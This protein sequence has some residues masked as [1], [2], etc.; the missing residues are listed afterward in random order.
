[1]TRYAADTLRQDRKGREVLADSQ[2]RRDTEQPVVSNGFPVDGLS[3]LDH[4]DKFHVQKTSDERRFLSNDEH[5]DGIAVRGSLC[6]IA[7]KSYGKQAPKGST[8]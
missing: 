7:P 6:G 2:T 1:M 8:N 3:G 5:V 4:P